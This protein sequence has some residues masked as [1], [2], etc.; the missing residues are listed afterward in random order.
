MKKKY[1]WLTSQQCLAFVECGLDVFLRPRTG[2]FVQSQRFELEML[3]IGK[4][5]C[6][7]GVFGTVVWNIRQLHEFVLPALCVS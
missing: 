7:Q 3:K 2:P 4:T 6:Q 1:D 5:G